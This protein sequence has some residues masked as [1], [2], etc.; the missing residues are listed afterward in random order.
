[1]CW[2]KFFSVHQK[3][4]N[5]DPKTNGWNIFVLS[6]SISRYTIT[7]SILHLRKGMAFWFR[8]T[9]ASCC[10]YLGEMPPS[11]TSQPDILTASRFQRHVTV[12][13]KCCNSTLT[14]IYIHFFSFVI[15]RGST[16]IIKLF[17]TSGLRSCE[18]SEKSRTCRRIQDVVRSLDF[19]TNFL[20]SKETIRE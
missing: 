19:I 5:K 6:V 15:A 8:R 16:S 18:P 10:A 9:A 11:C 17:H 3:I 12:N 1:M 4:E 7:R 20:C 13:V 2:T 14:H